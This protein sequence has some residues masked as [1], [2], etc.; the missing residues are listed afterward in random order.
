MRAFYF[1]TYLLLSPLFLLAQTDSLIL[2]SFEE[3][4]TWVKNN[5]P[6]ARQAALLPK[7]GKATELSAR[8]NFD[9]VTYT[10]IDQKYFDDKNYFSLLNSGLK[11]PTWFGIELKAG[12]ENNRGSFLS[13]ESSLPQQG[14]AYAGISLPL[15][16]GLFID[17]RRTTL[18]QA[19]IFAQASFAEQQ[20]ILNELMYEAGKAYWEWFMAYNK[21]VVFRNVLSV[22][23]LRFD[24][25]K[26]S[27][28]LGD[29]PYVDTLEAGIQVQDRKLNLQQAE[30]E[31]TN[32]SLMMSTFLWYEN[33]IP[34]ELG[35]NTIPPASETISAGEY[36]LAGFILKLDS[37]EQLHPQ[38]SLS[39]FKI[40][41]L[42]T[43][44]KWK[45]EKLK[46]QLNIQYNALSA[47]VNSD[48]FSN[49]SLNNYKWGLNFS[50]P[51]LLRKERGELQLAKLKVS[52]A[53][54]EL[55]N[56]TNQLLNKARMSINEQ[57][58][59]REQV[60]LYTGTVRDY[61]SLLSAEKRMFDSGESSLFMINMREMSAV[62]ARVKLIELI[63]KNRKNLLQV[64][65][66]FGEAGI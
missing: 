30:I 47:P 6:I 55:K 37:L 19:K 31:F 62:N 10:S 22:A 11:I 54:Y 45:A 59:S 51:L 8:G 53:N 66:T 46:P 33:E 58:V 2:F 14:L 63:T 4:S 20:S 9:P 60:K 34:L 26:Q 32:A 29:R 42:E 35:N 48:V 5:H 15:G 3:Y 28:G 12:Y 27:A 21:L 61:E 7:M 17:Q 41:T 43:E 57:N 18:Q 24:A 13:P 36:E 25:V 40:A 16:Q 39:R 50:M 1:L 38:L 56:K 23:Q 65:Y 64:A 49:Y 52:E 44:R